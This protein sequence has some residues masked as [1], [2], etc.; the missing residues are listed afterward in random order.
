MSRVVA[1][2]L[3][4]F[5]WSGQG[6]AEKIKAKDLVGVW[7]YVSAYQQRPDGT[8][9]NQFGDRPRGYF[10]IDKNGHYSHIVMDNALPRVASGLIKEMTPEEATRIAEGTLAHF[11]T[12]TVDE[13]GGTFT[14]TIV[15]SSFP[16]FDGVQQTRTVTVLTKDSLEYQNPVSSAG[17]GNVVFAV[18]RRLRK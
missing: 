14:V 16:N 13:H 3:I 10:I 4:L 5:C 15:K 2:V 9:F 11:G 18:L 8:R 7:E 12:Y 1:A 17:P 6:M